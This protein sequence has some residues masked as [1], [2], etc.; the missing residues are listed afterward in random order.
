MAGWTWSKSILSRVG[1]DQ[2]HPV[3]YSSFLSI[4]LSGLVLELTIQFDET[5]ARM[6]DRISRAEKTAEQA[7][8][9]VNQLAETLAK[10]QTVIDRQ[11]AMLALADKRQKKKDRMGSEGQKRQER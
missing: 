4:D 7:V 9:A 2:V 3:M 1:L 10:Q 8:A 5:L 11:A 6:N